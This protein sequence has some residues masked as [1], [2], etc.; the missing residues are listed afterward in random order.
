[1]LGSQALLP[2]YAEHCPG[3]A[4]MHDT[5]I[6]MELLGWGNYDQK[7]ELIT[8]YFPSSGTGQVNINFSV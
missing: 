7:G 8:D 5:V 3:E 1:M 2:D 6:L 4:S